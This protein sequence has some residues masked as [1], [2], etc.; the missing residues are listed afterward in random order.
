MKNY[1]QEHKDK[2][3]QQVVDN[4]RKP[5]NKEK[6]LCYSLLSR[7]NNRKKTKIRQSTIDKYE[8]Y[9]NDTG[10]WASKKYGSQYVNIA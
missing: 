4:M 8:L 2:I 6:N 9:L 1:Y 5:E 3:K 10:K 7:I